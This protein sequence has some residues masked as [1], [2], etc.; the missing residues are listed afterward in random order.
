M[1]VHLGNDQCGA[2]R[3][4]GPPS[5]HCQE[6]PAIKLLLSYHPLVL[7]SAEVNLQINMERCRALAVVFGG[8]WR[9][10]STTRGLTIGARGIEVT[11]MRWCRVGDQRERVLKSYEGGD[12]KV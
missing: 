5:R 12:K 2:V 3:P 11:S 8:G 6:R 1:T 7:H 9:G 4:G 10:V